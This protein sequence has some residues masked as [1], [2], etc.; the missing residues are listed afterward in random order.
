MPLPRRALPD[1]PP[2]VTV[3]RVVVIED[4]QSAR[5]RL[6]ERLHAVDGISVVGRVDVDDAISLA[7]RFRPDVILVNSDYMVSQILP[8]TTELRSQNPHF[9]F[10]VL[11]DPSMRGMLPP[12]RRAK[13]LSFIVKDTPA[14]LIAEAIRRVAGG[15]R[16]LDPRLQ[17]AALGT[18]KSVNTVEWEVLGLAAQGE[19]VADIAARMHLSLGTVRNYLSA[20]ITKT[21]ARNRL[22]AI[23][24][25]RKGGWLR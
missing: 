13:D 3:I 5:D 12:R 15:E 7:A 10:L 1:C 21:G 24:I 23:R 11:S 8:I 17:V 9:A 14:Q 2:G 16:V 25:A 18:E 20:V 19:T 4:S 22:D 6:A